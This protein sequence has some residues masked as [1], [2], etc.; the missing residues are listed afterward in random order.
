MT[1]LM[2]HEGA[3]SVD[4]ERLALDLDRATT[5]LY[6]TVKLA[7]LRNDPRFRLLTD[8]DNISVSTT[9]PNGHMY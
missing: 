8:I 9:L 3:A 2:T 7:R 1:A 5:A 4:I 6:F